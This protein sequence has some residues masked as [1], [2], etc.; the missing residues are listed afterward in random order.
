MVVILRVVGCTR[1]AVVVI[2]LC[3]MNRMLLAFGDTSCDWIAVTHRDIGGS[4]HIVVAVVLPV[5]IVDERHGVRVVLGQRQYK[6]HK[7]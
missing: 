5:C 1:V 2:D 3:G 6:R 4:R 7:S